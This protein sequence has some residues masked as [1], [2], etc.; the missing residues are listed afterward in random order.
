MAEAGLELLLLREGEEVAQVLHV[1]RL[2]ILMCIYRYI[3]V[4]TYVPTHIYMGQV[5][6]VQRLLDELEG[7][8][9]KAQA[10]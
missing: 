8:G 9:D 2:H 6:H 7:V 1:Q 3:S 4:C 5:L 10:L